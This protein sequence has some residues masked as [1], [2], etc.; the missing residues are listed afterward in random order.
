M[1]AHLGVSSVSSPL[2]AFPFGKKDQ[3]LLS[4]LNTS[5]SFDG[6]YSLCLQYPFLKF[7]AS[8]LIAQY[9]LL[10]LANLNCGKTCQ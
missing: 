7:L 3:M 5:D 10:Q 2:S 6:F 1:G 8:P 4:N 9:P